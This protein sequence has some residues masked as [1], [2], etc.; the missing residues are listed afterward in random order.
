MAPRGAC[1][2]CV[3]ILKDFLMQDVLP[4]LSVAPVQPPASNIGG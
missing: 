3:K 1:G 4:F 2:K